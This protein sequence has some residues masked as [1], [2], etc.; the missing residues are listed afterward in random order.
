MKKDPAV[1][2]PV[3]RR[4]PPLAVGLLVTA[5]LLLLILGPILATLLRFAVSRRREYLADATGAY[6]VSLPAG[7]YTVSLDVETLPDGI[8][9]RNPDANPLRRLALATGGHALAG[10]AGDQMPDLAATITDSIPR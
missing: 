7:V 4:L 2:R 5:G 8:N 3:T 10:S 6:T 9:L 1:T